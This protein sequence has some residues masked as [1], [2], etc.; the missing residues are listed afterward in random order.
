MKLVDIFE[1]ISTTTEKE[2]R[3][4]L[5]SRYDSNFVDYILNNASFSELLV[6]AK[7]VFLKTKNIIVHFAE[8]KDAVAILGLISKTQKLS[9]DDL[10]DIKKMLQRLL[11]AINK[12]KIAITSAN[13]FTEPIIR[14]FAKRENLVLD[15]IGGEFHY[16]N[17]IWKNFSISK[18]DSEQ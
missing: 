13:K 17:E 12:G 15:E 16:K 9:R 5:S 11:T 18:K 6:G 14:N 8:G 2:Y 1:E 3:D 4:V 10:P 7:S